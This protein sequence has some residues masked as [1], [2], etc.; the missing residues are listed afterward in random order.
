MVAALAAILPGANV[1]MVIALGTAVL[2]ILMYARFRRLGRID[3]VAVLA[4]LVCW[5]AMLGLLSL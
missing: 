2:A 1:P 5:A 3:E 4:I